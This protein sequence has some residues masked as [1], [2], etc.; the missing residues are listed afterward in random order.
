MIPKSETS[1]EKNVDWFVVSQN[2]GV[3]FPT[4]LSKVILIKNCAARIS[5]STIFLS[6]C[7]L[8]LWGTSNHSLWI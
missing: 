2:L 1:M 6:L 4:V 5:Y 7:E 8:K 3:S